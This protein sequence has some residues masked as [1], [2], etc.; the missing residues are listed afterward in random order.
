MF[1]KVALLSIVLAQQLCY[2]PE[3]QKIDKGRFEGGGEVSIVVERSEFYSTLNMEYPDDQIK[4]KYQTTILDALCSQA[5]EK[6]PVFGFGPTQQEYEGV[7]SPDARNYCSC[8]TYK[9]AATKLAETLKA[10]PEFALLG[11]KEDWE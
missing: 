5:N 3:Y 6:S 10:D 11:L 9:I 7:C 1:G 2:A 4:K 8:K